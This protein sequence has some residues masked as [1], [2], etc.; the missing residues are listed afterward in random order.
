MRNIGD[1][2]QKHKGDY[3][4]VGWI[5]G[6]VVKRSGQIRFVVENKDGV[7]FIFNDEQLI[8]YIGNI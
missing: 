3:K 7:L 8:P 4:F 6:I 5:V 2:V 1:K